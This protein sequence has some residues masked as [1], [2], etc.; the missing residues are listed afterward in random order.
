MELR[1]AWE[2]SPC[3]SPNSAARAC[4]APH[5]ARMVWR[6]SASWAPIWRSM[7]RAAIS[8]PRRM[9]SHLTESMPVWVSQAARP[10]AM[11]IFGITGDL[12]KRLLLPSLYN[13]ASQGLLS[14]HFA[15]VGFALSEISEDELRRR[16]SEELRLAC[17]RD[18]NIATIEWLV[19]RLRF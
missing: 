14:E 6:W 12:S 5:R 11:V 15:I 1:A 18:C 17:G 9:S 13:L 7:G 19:S 8:R 4:W 2:R 3:N 10:C 16:L